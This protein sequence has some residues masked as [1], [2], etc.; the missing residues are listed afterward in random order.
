MSDR[1]PP[2]R[3]G[4]MHAH[5]EHHLPNRPHPASWISRR[6]GVDSIQHTVSNWR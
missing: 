1:T 5:R 2:T 6:G 4:G 3:A